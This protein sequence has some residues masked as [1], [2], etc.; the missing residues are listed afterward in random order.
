MKFKL[1]IVP[2]NSIYVWFVNRFSQLTSYYS[3][4]YKNFVLLIMGNI[5]YDIIYMLLISLIFSFERKK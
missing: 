4:N 1:Y 3:N 2:C 5:I